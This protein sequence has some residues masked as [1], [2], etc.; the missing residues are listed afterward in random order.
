VALAVP[1]TPGTG[2]E[3]T[4][5]ATIWDTGNGRKLSL[6]GEVVRPRCCV[7]DPD[8]L[9]GLDRTV[10]AHAALDTMCQ[11]A[12]AAWSVHS[13]ETSIAHGLAAVGLAGGVLD[14]IAQLRL[15]TVDKL[16][17]LLAG[18]HSGQA[19]TLAQTSSCHA[20]SYPL[21][22]RLGLAHGHACG[23]SLPR[24]MRYNAAVT[25]ANCVD[26]RGPDH[27]GRVIDRIREALGESTVARAAARI[28][29]FLGACGLAHFDDLPVAADDIAT[30]AL[31]YP[32]CSDNPRQL[33]VATLS[34]LLGTPVESEEPCF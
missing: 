24:L 4:P 25:A 3:V 26:P 30:E 14:R 10:L 9:A 16:A 17:M 29:D 1:T 33:T 15:R 20:I 18:H 28:E 12:E 34:R 31:S 22:L 8:L 6:T 2:A 23:V 7:L 32:R 19:I 27:V 21:T 11:G 13:T 5:F